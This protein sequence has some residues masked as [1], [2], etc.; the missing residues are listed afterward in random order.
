[1]VNVK[2]NHKLYIDCQKSYLKKCNTPKFKYTIKNYKNAT[3]YM[4]LKIINI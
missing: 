1:M 3:K 4:K 2:R